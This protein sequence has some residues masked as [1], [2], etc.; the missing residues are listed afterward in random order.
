MNN[1]FSL[2]AKVDST[3]YTRSLGNLPAADTYASNAGRSVAALY[4]APNTEAAMQQGQGSDED[5]RG[6]QADDIATLMMGGSGLDETVGTA[7]DYTIKVVYAGMT[8]S[9]DIV[10]TSSTST[11]FAS[12][13]FGGT[14]LAPNHAAITTGTFRYNP[15]AVTWFFNPIL[16]CDSIML[17]YAHDA[18]ISHVACGSITADEGF[19][20]GM[21]GTVSLT[22]SKVVLNNG[23]KVAKT[24]TVH[25]NLN[26]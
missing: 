9:C 14:L 17:D 11:A 16:A 19:E 5:Q 12:C 8:T 24:G 26:P 21:T 15:T 10:A 4:G 3:N 7:D 18:L 20:V 1:P 13:S 6:L 25:I 23:T 2:P 22:G